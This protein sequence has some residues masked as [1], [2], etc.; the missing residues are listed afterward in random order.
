NCAVFYD[1][2]ATEGFY[3]GLISEGGSGV[4][5]LPC[6]S[7]KTIVGLAVIAL[8]KSETLIICTNIVAIRQWIDEILDKTNVES[9]DV[10]EY[11]GE[12]KRIRPITLTTYQMLTHRTSKDAEFKHFSIFS[13]KD[14]GL[15]IYDEVHLLPAPVFRMT[16]SLQAKRRLG[17]TATLVREDGLEADV[18][19]LIGPKKFDVPWKDLENKG[20]IAEAHCSEIRVEMPRDLRRSYSLGLAHEK[21]R[22]AAENYRKLE[23]VKRLV[24]EYAEEQILIIGVYI[25]HLQEIADMLDAPFIHGA[26]PNVEREVL[27]DDFRNSRTRI[28]VVSKVANFAVDL[29]DASVAIQ[30]SGTFGSR[31]EEA[32]RLGR[33]LRPKS[34]GQRAYFFSIVSKDTREQEAAQN[35]QRFLTEQGYAYSIYDWREILGEG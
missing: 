14:W 20:W 12:R 22:L 9:A 35:R 21:H 7:G 28:L 32:Q 17:L 19:S 6:G 18:F 4:I 33:I 11:S 13:E 26:T 34:R 2:F 24:A 5:V 10:G 1:E 27:Y 29:P 30:V 31:Q 8:V 16:A 15:I 23:I 25:R 3:A